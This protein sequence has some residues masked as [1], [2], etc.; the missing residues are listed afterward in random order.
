[1]WPSAKMW[2]TLLLAAIP[3]LS[4]IVLQVTNQEA[5]QKTVQC[6][7]RQALRST[8]IPHFAAGLRWT[9]PNRGEGFDL[10]K[11]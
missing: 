4:A 2:S 11:R 1:M 5:H 6:L 10:K 9:T 7:N 8:A 3:I